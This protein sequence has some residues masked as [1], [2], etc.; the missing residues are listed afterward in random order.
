MNVNDL[1]N[2]FKVNTFLPI[3]IERNL[4]S[5][6]VENKWGRILIVAV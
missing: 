1:I 2:S 3:L 5:G 6:M 4:L